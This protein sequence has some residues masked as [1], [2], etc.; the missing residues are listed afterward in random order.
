MARIVIG[1]MGPGD[2]ATTE[3]CQL[4]ERLGERIADKGWVT[5][6][7][8]RPSGVMEAALR[9]ARRRNGLTVGVLPGNVAG[10]GSSYADIR[11]VTGLGEARNAINVL[12]SDVVCVCGM[13]AGTASEVALALKANRPTILL[14]PAAASEQFWRSLDSEYLHVARTVDDAIRLI[15]RI[16]ISGLANGE[17][18]S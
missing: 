12:S 3:D 10:D 9:G 5:L 7:G 14:A 15:A 8:G 4:A 2:T 18:P 1:V 16:T 17:P 11:I 6:T 13:N